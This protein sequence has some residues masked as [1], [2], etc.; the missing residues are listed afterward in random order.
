MAQAPPPVAHLAQ[1]AAASGTHGAADRLREMLERQRAAKGAA[2]AASP[3]ISAVPMRLAAGTGELYLRTDPKDAA[4]GGI[5]I[6]IGKPTNKEEESKRIA[7]AAKAVNTAAPPD[8]NRNL[9]PIDNLQAVLD[10]RRPGCV[11][12]ELD[13]GSNVLA[14]RLDAAKQL[15]TPEERAIFYGYSQRISPQAMERFE[16]SKDENLNL[17]T[18]DMARMMIPPCYCWCPPLVALLSGPDLAPPAA[19]GQEPLPS[20]EVQR[21]A[22]IQMPYLLRYLQRVNTTV[23]ALTTTECMKI[24]DAERRRQC[25]EALEA[26]KVQFSSIDAE[27][28]LDFDKVRKW[29][30]GQLFGAASVPKPYPPTFAQLWGDLADGVRLETRTAPPP[31]S[32]SAGASLEALKARDKMI[33]MRAVLEALGGML[34]D[35]AG[36]KSSTQCSLL[37]QL[38]NLKAEDFLFWGQPALPLPRTPSERSGAWP[39]GGFAPDFGYLALVANLRNTRLPEGYDVDAML[40]QLEVDKALITGTRADAPMEL[41]RSGGSLSLA[42]VYYAFVITAIFH[43]V[44]IEA[45]K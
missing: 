11:A 38:L 5:R 9:H 24:T 33:M 29:A 36:R 4:A 26:T 13:A 39:K 12:L 45:K 35:I 31:G 43:D 28:G 17:A 32:V 18:F 16:A 2:N 41:K 20:N 22:F 14:L 19:E 44:P 25:E 27:L 15:L 10:A 34:I 8:A 7:E 3:H 30:M 21:A 37:C 6:E 42:W 1:Q 23:S 40:A